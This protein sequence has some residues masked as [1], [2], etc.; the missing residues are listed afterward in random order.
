MTI[1][2]DPPKRLYLFKNRF[3][4]SSKLRREPQTCECG[5]FTVFC[6]TGT[7]SL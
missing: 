2:Y 5:T 6:V 1:N 4:S 7:E 3:E